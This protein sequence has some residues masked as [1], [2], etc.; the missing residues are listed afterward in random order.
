MSVL[1]RTG[2]TS[3]GLRPPSPHPM[4]RRNLFVGRFGFYKYAAPLALKRV[5][6]AVEHINISK[7]AA[8]DSVA[9]AQ[10]FAGTTWDFVG[11]V[12]ISRGASWISR[13]EVRI[14]RKRFRTTRETCGFRGSSADLAGTRQ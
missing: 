14:L 7:T 9:G 1:A 10:D 2:D 13:A 8:W 4:R 5:P 3:S 12:R 11:G 6:N